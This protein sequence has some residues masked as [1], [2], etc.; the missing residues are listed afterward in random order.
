MFLGREIH[1]HFAPL[2]ISPCVIYIGKILKA[3]EYASWAF[4]FVKYFIHVYAYTV[5]VQCVCIQHELDANI[6]NVCWWGK[7]RSFKKDKG[8]ENQ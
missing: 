6:N 5:L 8:L 7:K 3:I 4:E 2:K 1:D